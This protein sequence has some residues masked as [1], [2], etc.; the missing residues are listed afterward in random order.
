MEDNIKAEFVAIKLECPYFNE[1]STAKYGKFYQVVVFD[2]T[3]RTFLCSL[4]PNYFMLH[5][6]Y[7][8]A[9]EVYE[10]LSEEEAEKLEDFLIEA[11]YGGDLDF[12]MNM[13]DVDDIMEKNEGVWSLVGTSDDTEEYSVFDARDDYRCNPIF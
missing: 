12:Y 2:R 8:V 7:T 1:E 11:E 5:C 6:G 3:E 4:T 13:Y 9:P 10:G